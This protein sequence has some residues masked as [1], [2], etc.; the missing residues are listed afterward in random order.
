MRESK[1]CKNFKYR[2]G[3]G[4]KGVSAGVRTTVTPRLNM[5]AEGTQ[6]EHDMARYAPGTL[7]DDEERS[8]DG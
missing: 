3:K 1:Q 4:K 7:A 6:N 5:L 8:L 2:Q